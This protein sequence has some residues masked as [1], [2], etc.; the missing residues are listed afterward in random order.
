MTTI[1]YHHESKTIAWDSRTTEG[2]IIKTDSAIKVLERNGVKFWLTGSRSDYELLIDAYFGA[3]LK[4]VPEASAIVLDGG[5]FYS[6]SVNEDAVFWRQ[7]MESNEAIGSGRYWAMAAMDFGK[8]PK[9]AV[10]YAKT[11]DCYTGGE[12]HEL[13]LS[14]E[15]TEQKMTRAQANSSLMQAEASGLC[16]HGKNSSECFSCCIEKESGTGVSKS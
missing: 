3:E 1:A 10:E 16:H 15:T 13:C 6:C 12:V 8:T 11:R 4:V 9:Q 2:G 7:N 14:V 5:E